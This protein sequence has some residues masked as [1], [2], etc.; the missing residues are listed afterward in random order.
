MAGDSDERAA[1]VERKVEEILESVARGS[2]PE[3]ARS[4]AAVR[5]ADM[6]F[7][8]PPAASLQPQRRPVPEQPED[9]NANAVV[10]AAMETLSRYGITMEH[11]HE[12]LLRWIREEE[13]RPQ[14][15]QLFPDC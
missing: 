8:P 15:A 10:E 12:D 7:L 13:V 1:E 6:G 4:D 3:M 9:A 2:A 11:I 5:L 14:V